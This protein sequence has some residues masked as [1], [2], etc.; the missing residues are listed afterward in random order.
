M[1]TA[2]LTARSEAAG[3]ERHAGSFAR[4]WNPMANAKYPTL[5]ATPIPLTA[6]LDVLPVRGGE[7]FLRAVFEPLGYAVE[8]TRRPLD[9]RFPQIVLRP[10]SGEERNAHGDADRVRAGGR[11]GHA[12]ERRPAGVGGQADGGKRG[13]ADLANSRIRAGS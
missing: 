11:A 8:V 1:A 5:A 13:G 4:K 3:R 10:E 7:R 12:G 2:R 9:P 6:R